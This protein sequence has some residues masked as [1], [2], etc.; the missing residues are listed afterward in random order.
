MK[1]KSLYSVKQ[2]E[3]LMEYLMSF[4]DAI[5]YFDLTTEEFETT[6]KS[7]KRNNAAGIDTIDPNIVLDTLIKS[8]ILFLIFKT[9]LQQGAFPNRYK[10]PKLTR[11]FKSGDGEN[12]T[13][14]KLISVLLVFSKIL[15]RIMNNRIYKHLKSNSWLFDKTFGFQLNNFTEHSI[16]QLVNDFFLVLSR[17]ENIH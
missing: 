5:S 9:S 17:E 7:L 16:F 12:V 3:Y 2:I 14:Y 8:D 10:T 13:K 1:K 4:N 11:L 6:F 15:E